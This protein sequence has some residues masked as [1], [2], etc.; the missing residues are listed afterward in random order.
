MPDKIRWGILGCGKIAA[1]FAADLRLVKDAEL[2][3]VASRD[4][5]R[6]TEFANTFGAKSIFDNYEALATSALD[7]I[8]I[9][10]PHSFHY[11]HTLLCLQQ[12]KAVLCEKPFA[13]NFRQA[14]EM[15]QLARENQVFLMEAF[16]SKF[17]PQYKKIIE[18]IDQGTIGSIQ[19]IQADFG[20]KASEPIPARLWDAKLGGGALLDIGIY[21]VF[22]A[23]SLMGKPEEISAHVTRFPGGVDQQ[24]AITFR[25]KSGALS[26]LFCTLAADTPVQAI[27]SGTLGRIELHD[28]FHNATAR[29]YLALGKDPLQEVDVYRQDGYGYQ[30]E[31]QHVTDCLMTGMTESPVML[32]QD[33][34]D[35]IE[36][37]DRIRKVADIRYPE[38]QV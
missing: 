35:L 17:L 1:K 34:L 26:S 37:L 12:K 11:E 23:Q 30:F 27:I 32:H 4:M 21:P 13:I 15:V 24:C 33:T 29:V 10:T 6:A 8:Y 16:W 2:V 20:F 38:D 9:A 14:S 18:L 7:V 22:L 25:H 31:A 36:T 5:Q 19:W 28:R 3:G